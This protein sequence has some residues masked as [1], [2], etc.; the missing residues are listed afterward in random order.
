MKKEN[1]EDN[2]RELE[3]RKEITNKRK[4]AAEGRGVYCR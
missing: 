1:K 3:I 2:E 4:E